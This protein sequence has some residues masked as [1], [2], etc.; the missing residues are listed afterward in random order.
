MMKNYNQYR[1]QNN[2][3]NTMNK[4]EKWFVSEKEVGILLLRLFI[5]LRL[6]Y[7]VV[8]NIT[9][10]D[11]MMEFSGF[12]QSQN[13]PIPTICAMLSVYAQLVCGILILLGYKTRMASA[14][15]TVNFIVAAFVHLRMKDTVE[16]MTPALAMLMGCIVLLFY[17]ND[18]FSL[19]RRRKQL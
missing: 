11:R 13:F 14:I 8:D 16:N 12:L 4:I 10:W 18:K 6:L 19:T 1:K 15:M 2:N 7:G 5:S 3:L 17:D 9:S